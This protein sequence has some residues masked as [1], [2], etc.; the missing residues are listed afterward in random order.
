VGD[1]VIH[2]KCLKFDKHGAQTEIVEEIEEFRISIFFD[3]ES[4]NHHI[5]FKKG[6]SRK[7]IRLLFHNLADR[8]L[9]GL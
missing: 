5:Q 2:I 6:I 1:K 3:Y 8:L 9:G 4:D 7:E